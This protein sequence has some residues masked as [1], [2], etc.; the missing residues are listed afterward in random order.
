MILMK[1]TNILKDGTVVE[2]MSTVVVPSDKLANIISIIEE[3]KGEKN[4]Q[5]KNSNSCN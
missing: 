3:K 2:D 1:V 4:G 5:I